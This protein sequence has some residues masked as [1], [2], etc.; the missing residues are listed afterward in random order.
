[1]SHAGPLKGILNALVFSC[2]SRIFFFDTTPNRTLFMWWESTQLLHTL[3]SLCA[4]QKP[5]C[6]TQMYRSRSHS[7]SAHFPRSHMALGWVPLNQQLA[8][9]MQSLAFDS[10]PEHDK[11]FYLPTSQYSKS[12]PPWP[13][14]HWLKET[15]S[16]IKTGRGPANMAH[17]SFSQQRAERKEGGGGDRCASGAVAS[18]GSSSLC[19]R[20]SL[21]FPWLCLSKER[22]NG[23]GSL[24]HSS[25]TR[26]LRGSHMTWTWLPVWPSPLVSHWGCFLCSCQG[27]WDWKQVRVLPTVASISS[28]SKMS[29]LQS[30][31][32]EA[33]RFSIHSSNMFRRCQLFRT[34]GILLNRTSKTI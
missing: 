5:E 11:R 32:S 12:I 17:P 14:S 24:C 10:E 27:S 2:W 16:L 18:H 34:A 20:S 13:G 26:L 29:K 28:G 33:V 9:L 8:A 30:T 31:L 25:L 23:Q 15:M 21:S 22:L 4:R 6:S 7:H 19:S 3:L 1:M